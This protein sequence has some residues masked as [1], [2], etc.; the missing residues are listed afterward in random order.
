M[1]TASIA[2]DE[3]LMLR[4]FCKEHDITEVSFIKERGAY[5]CAKSGSEQEGDQKVCIRYLSGMDPSNDEDNNNY[6]DWHDTSE[7]KFG[8]S[9]VNVT[10]PVNWLDYVVA[11]EAPFKRMFSIRIQKSVVTLLYVDGV[12]PFTKR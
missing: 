1:A 11:C 3:A 7:I 2:R 9:N 12:A 6:R 5:F 8:S 10:F 4:D